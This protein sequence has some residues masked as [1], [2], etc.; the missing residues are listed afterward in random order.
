M[1]T[2][3]CRC[4]IGVGGGNT[5]QGTGL[6]AAIDEILTNGSSGSIVT[7]HW[8]LMVVLQSHTLLDF[9]LW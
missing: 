6:D 3:G 7:S 1:R 2:L 5:N 4:H 8:C 9:V